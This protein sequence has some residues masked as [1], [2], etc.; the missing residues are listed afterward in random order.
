MR[1]INRPVL[2][3]AAQIDPS[4]AQTVP[5]C[6]FILNTLFFMQ[7]LLVFIILSRKKRFQTM[8]KIFVTKPFR[9][10]VTVRRIVNK[11]RDLGLN[12]FLCGCVFF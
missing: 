10:Y 4:S 3:N 7:C 12:T 1:S 9:C 6:G 11:L 2:Y 5:V 8:M